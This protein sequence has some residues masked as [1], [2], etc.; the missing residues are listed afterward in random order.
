MGAVLMALLGMGVLGAA[1]V[2]TQSSDEND[3]TPGSQ[4]ETEEVEARDVLHLNALDTMTGT[5]AGEIFVAE[6]ARGEDGQI[7]VV[8][9]FDPD[10]DIVAF[11]LE[12][13]ARRCFEDTDSSF[14]DDVNLDYTLNITPSSDTEGGD[15]TIITLSLFNSADAASDAVHFDVLLQGIDQID[16]DSISVVTGETGL[17]QAQGGERASVIEGTDYDDTLSLTDATELVSAGDGDDTIT[18]AGNSAFILGGAGND[19]ISV[20]GTG[21][22]IYGGSGNDDID[23]SAHPADVAVDA[24]IFG[25]GGDDTIVT[26]LGGHVEGGTGTDNIVFSVTDTP[27]NGQPLEL[28]RQPIEDARFQGHSTVALD[29]SQD[30]IRLEIDPAVPGHLHQVRLTEETYGLNDQ[31]VY[32]RDYTLIIWSPEGITDIADLVTGSGSVFNSSFAQDHGVGSSTYEAAVNDPGAPRILLT[33]D[34]GDVYGGDFD[35]IQGTISGG[36]D[37]SH[38]VDIVLNREVTSVHSGQVY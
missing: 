1:L 36:Y 29:D 22:D 18:G 8:D 10:A 5:E 24:S 2:L 17:T 14:S 27:T 26:E 31:E 19:S 4:D 7:S 38:D 15:G 21:H 33:I 20:T 13:L 16:E 6:T 3:E 37:N 28:W 25:G 30:T 12:D 35:E 9:E 11:D 34:H 32:T 23:V